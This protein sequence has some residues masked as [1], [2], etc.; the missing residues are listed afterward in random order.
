MKMASI[1]MIAFYQRVEIRGPSFPNANK[2]Q[3]LYNTVQ[4]QLGTA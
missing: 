1:W 2:V 3:P 4:N